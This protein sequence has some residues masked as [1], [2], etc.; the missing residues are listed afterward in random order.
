LI[1]SV[2]LSRLGVPTCVAGQI[3]GDRHGASILRILRLN[4]VETTM[5]TTLSEHRTKINDIK[6]RLDGLWH[7]IGCQP[8]WFPYLGT[9]IT[10]S[11]L[12]RYSHLHIAGL[13]SML[14][15]VPKATDLLMKSFREVGKPVSVGLTALNDSEAFRVAQSI[16]SEDMLFCDQQEFAQLLGTES[17]CPENVLETAVSSRFSKCVVTLG[18]RGAV[19]RWGCSTSFRVVAPASSA[20]NCLGA[21]DV[22]SAVFVAG[23]LRRYP[24]TSC[25]KLAT[26]AAVESVKGALW[27]TWLRN[28]SSLSRLEAL[29]EDAESGIEIV[30]V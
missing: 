17:R 27:D 5:L 10:Q 12:N 29:A 8:A 23:S 9:D 21:G 6:V 4:D 18:R 16:A 22:F 2:V 13:S 15:A 24:V 11:D 14:R 19:G 20:L 30:E 26:I 7:R 1:F 25:A 3:A 28:C